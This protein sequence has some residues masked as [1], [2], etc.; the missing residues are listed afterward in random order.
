MIGNPLK[1]IAMV[2]N[3]ICEGFDMEYG[4]QLGID[5]FP[6]ELKFVVKLKSARGRDKGDVESIFNNGLGRIY[7][8]PD[9]SLDLG[10]LS[11]S[12]FA[13]GKPTNKKKGTTELSKDNGTR[14]YNVAKGS[15]Y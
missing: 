13:D 6:T 7:Y 11:A 10:N 2:G 8:P 5:D 14:K 3:L 4:D 15:V 12:T 9:G 1:P